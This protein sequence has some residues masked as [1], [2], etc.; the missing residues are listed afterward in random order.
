MT[1]NDARVVALDVGSKRI[2]VATANVIARLPAP[3]RT[4]EVGDDIVQQI[5]ELLTEQ[6][7]VALVVGLPRGL[8]GQDTAQTRTIQDFVATFAADLKIP[9]YWQDEAVT[10]VLSEAVLQAKKQEYTKGDIDAL[11][12][13]LILDDFLTTHEGEL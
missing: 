5:H 1:N 13:T 4:L 9:L 10:S 11:A 6:A 8:E 3:L 12:A 7:A 2:G